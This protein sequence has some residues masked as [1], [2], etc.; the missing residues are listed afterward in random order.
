MPHRTLRQIVGQQKLLHVSPETNVLDAARQMADRHVAAMLV[1]ERG[2]L[3]GIFTERDL[4]RRVVIAGLAPEATR[5]GDVMSPHPIAIGAD[6]S[7]T[8]ALRVMAEAG[9]RH[10][11]VEGCGE[12]GF[13]ILSMRDFMS[14]EVAEAEREIN[15]QRK[16]WEDL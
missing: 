16:L 1:T 15:F 11:I 8:E 2:K 12:D 4:L 6:Q 9:V 14:G 7:G 5:I 13:A 10:L 3:A